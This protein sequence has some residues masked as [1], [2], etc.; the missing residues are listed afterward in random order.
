MNTPPTQ[1]TVEDIA[2]NIAYA[3]SA[4]HYNEEAG[5]RGWQEEQ[6]KQAITAERTI[7]DGLR[8]ELTKRDICPATHEK[9]ADYE[10]QIAELRQQLADKEVS[11]RVNK[12]V[13][14]N[15]VS[16]LSLAVSGLENIANSA[17]ADDMDATPQ[18]AQQLL[19]TLKGDGK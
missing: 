17:P 12:D 13:L 2:N 8:K 7:A 9:C 15:T 10:K 11:L 14:N 3:S 18:Y 19:T 1:R 5:L 16:K 4:D 6:I